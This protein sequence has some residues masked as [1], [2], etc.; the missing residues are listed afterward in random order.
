M[1]LHE[2]NF[3]ED[4]RGVDP[5]GFPGGREHQSARRRTN[6]GNPSSCSS[7]RICSLSEGCATKSR[8]AARDILPSS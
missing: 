7:L 5:E 4:A 8:P 6:S 1:G 2:I 3:L